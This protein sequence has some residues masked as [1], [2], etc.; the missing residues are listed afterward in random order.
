MET[1]TVELS[2][3]AVKDIKKVP[4]HIR[5]KF[6][7][8]VENIERIGLRETRKIKGFH[9]EPLTGTRKGQ[10]SIRLSRA[11]RAIYTECD[12]GVLELNYIEVDEVNKHDY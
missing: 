2:S 9:D 10:R 12:K 6:M 5:R 11:Y 7:L 8:W 3:Q 4:I 1:R